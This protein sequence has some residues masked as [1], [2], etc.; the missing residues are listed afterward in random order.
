MQDGNTKLDKRDGFTI[1]PLLIL[2]KNIK[3]SGSGMSSAEE[4]HTPSEYNYNST[5]QRS[6]Q[7]LTKSLK[8]HSIGQGITANMIS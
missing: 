7:S 1:N 4:V 8:N 3:A 2:N 6:F 5:S